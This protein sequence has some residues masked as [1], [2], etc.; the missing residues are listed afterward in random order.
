MDYMFLTPRYRR[1]HALKLSVHCC[2]AITSET[3][4][5][6]DPHLHYHLHMV[7]IAKE[8]KLV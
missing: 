4:L 8:V 6:L 2:S 5:W 3:I 1:A 7:N